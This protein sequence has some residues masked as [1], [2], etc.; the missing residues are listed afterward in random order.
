MLYELLAGS[1][2]LAG[3]DAVTTM[4]RQVHEEAPVL[5]TA[6]RPYLAPIAP[7]V[8]RALAKH[9]TDRYSSARAFGGALAD[10]AAAGWGRSWPS[11]DALRIMSPGPIEATTGR[12]I[13]GGAGWGSEAPATRL[14]ADPLAPSLPP[15]IL[16]P[17]PAAPWAPPPPE[18]SRYPVAPPPPPPARGRTGLWLA[19]AA[20]VV[21]VAAGAV[22][23]ATKGHSPSTPVTTPTTGPAGAA[24]V[25]A[26]L[27]SL[28]RQTANARSQLVS[29]VAAVDNC[30]ADP[31]TA[32]ASL[33]AAVTT[34]QQVVSQLAT[35]AVDALPNGQAMRLALINALNDSIDADRH[36]AAWQAGINAAGGCHGQ[37]PHD[38][39]WQAAQASSSAATGA[40]QTFAALWNPVAS[41]YGLPTVSSATI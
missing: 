35:L 6:G 16:R 4:Y 32:A 11:G 31:A 26:S 8:M 29:T 17:P 33:A 24:Q 41:R 3:N 20:V 25:A 34:R 15:T 36:F 5:L 38:A 19:V 22:L 10:A 18:T 30:S 7:V 23:L 2:P 12:T 37:A 28:I 39:N 40:K 14:A 27:N 9:P 21:V 13:S 1:H